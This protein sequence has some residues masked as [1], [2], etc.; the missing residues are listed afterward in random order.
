MQEKIDTLLTDILAHMALSFSGLL[1]QL[2][3]KLQFNTAFP[4]TKFFFIKTE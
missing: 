4:Q 2:E 3:G 1:W